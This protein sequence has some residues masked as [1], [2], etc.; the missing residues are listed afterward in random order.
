MKLDTKGLTLALCV[1][2]GGLMFLCGL[3]NLIFPG[4]AVAFLDWA[5][6]FY[7][8][9]HGPAG[10]G[11]VVVVTLYALV[12]GAVCGL[13]IAWL[14]NRFSAGRPASSAEARAF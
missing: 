5:A 14:Y 6:S 8:G 10:F 7:P 11:S 2:W 3:A 4:Y 1:L 13:L 9:Y 12:D